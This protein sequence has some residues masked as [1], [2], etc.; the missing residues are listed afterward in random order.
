MI[1]NACPH[2]GRHERLHIGKSSAGWCFAVNVHP[3]RGIETWEAWKDLLTQSKATII[4]EY[5]E[6]VSLDELIYNVENRSHPNGL[7][8]HEVDGRYCVSNG[9]GTWDCLTGDFS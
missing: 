7:K 4:N 2:C 1:E 3:D 6:P 9:V 8:R 5:D